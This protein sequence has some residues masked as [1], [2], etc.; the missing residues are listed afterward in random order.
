MRQPQFPKV[1]HRKAAIRRSRSHESLTMWTALFAC[2]AFAPTT[3]GLSENII[4]GSDIQ[5]Y[6]CLPKNYSR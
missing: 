2:L 1:L 4:C 3:F 5:T 6:V